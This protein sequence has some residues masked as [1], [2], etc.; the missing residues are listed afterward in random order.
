MNLITFFTS[1]INLLPDSFIQSFVF[2]NFSGFQ[3]VSHIL[4]TVNYFVPV[5]HLANIMRLWVPIM[6]A[7]VLFYVIKGAFNK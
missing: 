4:K 2:D 5:Y 7:V 3:T 6:S 1:L